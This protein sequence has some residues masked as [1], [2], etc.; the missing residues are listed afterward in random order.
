[1]L[2]TS[3]R[4]QYLDLSMASIRSVSV[5]YSTVQYSTVTVQYSTVGCSTSTSAWPPS[6]QCPRLYHLKC[7]YYNEETKETISYYIYLLNLSNSTSLQP[8]VSGAGAVWLLHAAE[9]RPGDV[10]P[11]RHRLSSHRRSVRDTWS[12]LEL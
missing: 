2:E 3:S 8:R 5:Q 11:H 7:Y 12:Y 1:M 4:L 6:G 9:P 10:Q